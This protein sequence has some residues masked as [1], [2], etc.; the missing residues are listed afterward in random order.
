[1]TEVWEPWVPTRWQR[2]RVRLSGECRE[3]SLY[4]LSDED[5][6]GIHI[7]GHDP[8]DD[9]AVGVVGDNGGHVPPR[10]SFEAH[11]FLVE[12]DE[13]TI[14][15]ATGYRNWCGYFAAAELEPIE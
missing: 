6:D 1:M 4:Y 2:V 14:P 10:N 9:G 15:H 11:R 12:F 13:P 7:E 8:A 5:D 3:P